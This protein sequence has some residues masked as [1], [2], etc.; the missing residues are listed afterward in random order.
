MITVAA[1][2][3]IKKSARQILYL[4]Q[5]PTKKIV[6]QA[7]VEGSRQQQNKATSPYQEMRG[8]YIQDT[9]KIYF[10]VDEVEVIRNHAILKEHK[11]LLFEGDRSMYLRKS[12]IQTA[13]YH[14]LVQLSN[15]KLE[16]ATFYVNKGN[17]KN[18]LSLAPND[19]TSVLIFGDARYNVGVK[20]PAKIVRE[21]VKKSQATTSW[22]DANN[23]DEDRFYD[24]IQKL[25]YTY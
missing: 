21:L 22:T 19:I 5:N 18:F 4:N 16:T 15:G 13:A 7:N 11:A 8:V 14:S 1:S 2:D 6:T 24:I 17:K 23:F 9:T 10:S 3:L 12:I 20:D 25:I